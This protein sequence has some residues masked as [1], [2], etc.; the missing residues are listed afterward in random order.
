MEGIDA[1]DHDEFTH[2]PGGEGKDKAGE[3]LMS[4]V[5]RLAGKCDQTKDDVHGKGKGSRKG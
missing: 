5:L 2:I 1:A 3:E 4:H